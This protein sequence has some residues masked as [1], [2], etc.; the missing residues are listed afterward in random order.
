MIHRLWQW[1]ADR[2]IPDGMLIV[3]PHDE[4]EP[5]TITPAFAA[6]MAKG[7]SESIDA[8]KSSFDDD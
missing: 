4:W 7:I 5:P 8:T 6:G 2:C 3:G 1:I